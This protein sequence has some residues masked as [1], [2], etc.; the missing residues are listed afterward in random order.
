DWRFNAKT[1]VLG[2][3]IK[4]ACLNDVGVDG[5][6]EACVPAT[7]CLDGQVCGQASDGCGR[8]IECGT[9]PVGQACDVNNYCVCIPLATCLVGRI[10][11]TA[12]DGCGGTMTCGTCSPGTICGSDNLCHDAPCDISSTTT[13]CLQ[14]RGMTGICL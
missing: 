8:M 7:A 13:A 14:P 12:P 5:S 10:C 11:G 2:V 1:F 3:E 9:C 6:P 4:L